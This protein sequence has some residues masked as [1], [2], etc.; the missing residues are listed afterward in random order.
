MQRNTEYTAWK[1]SKYGVL[2]GPYFPLFSPDTGKYGP[3]KTRYFDTFH[4]VIDGPINAH[5]PSKRATLIYIWWLNCTMW[6]KA[7]TNNVDRVLENFLTLS[8]RKSR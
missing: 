4:T 3:E 8:W 7:R 2:F 6:K 5:L 1:V